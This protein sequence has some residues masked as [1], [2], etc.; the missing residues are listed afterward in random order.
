MGWLIY[1]RTWLNIS[2]VFEYRL[3]KI[4]MNHHLVVLEDNELYMCCNQTVEQEK[5][6]LYNSE[7]KLTV[8]TY[9]ND[10]LLNLYR[11][12]GSFWN[13]LEQSTLVH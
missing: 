3:H 13:L 4:S 9:S 6:Y 8:T 11:R 1:P 10:P 2:M 7:L 5:I 12:T